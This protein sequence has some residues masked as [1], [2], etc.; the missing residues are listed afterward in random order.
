MSPAIRIRNWENRVSEELEDPIKFNKVMQDLQDIALVDAIRSL[1]LGQE[2]YL[3]IKH[4]SIPLKMNLY[5]S[6]RSLARDWSANFKSQLQEQWKRQ[7]GSVIYFPSLH[8]AHLECTKGV[9]TNKLRDHWAWQ[10]CGVLPHE[11]GH[12]NSNSVLG[13]WCQHS[14]QRNHFQISIWRYLL[15]S[16]LLSVV[17]NR[18]EPRH[19]Q[20]HLSGLEHAFGHKFTNLLNTVEQYTESF[21]DQVLQ[22]DSP[23][24][25]LPK[26]SSANIC[27][28]QFDKPASAS[29]IGQ[30]QYFKLPIDSVTWRYLAQNSPSSLIK[31][32]VTVLVIKEPGII[33]LPANSLSTRLPF[34]LGM[35]SEAREKE[36][37]GSQ[38]LFENKT[39]PVLESPTNDNDHADQIKGSSS[40]AENYLDTINESVS[41]IKDQT[42]ASILTHYAGIFWLYNLFIR[43]PEE[44]DAL[45]SDSRFGHKSQPWIWLWMVYPLICSSNQPNPNDQNFRVLAPLYAG[46][47]ESERLEELFQQIPTKAEFDLLCEFAATIRHRFLELTFPNVQNK[48]NTFIEILRRRARITRRGPW[49]EVQYSLEEVD[50]DVRRAGLDADPGFVVWLGTVVRFHYA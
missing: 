45:L 34:L 28:D 29:I 19:W 17:V 31:L 4:L 49:M 30:S 7:D 39:N 6:V 9:L 14:I 13:L 11:V 42:D 50:I 44:L 3:C 18:F 36:E 46:L 20:Q 27:L 32:L 10:Q 37:V 43:E 22:T 1:G 16:P 38:S 26:T 23:K 33:K 35:S 25:G 40:K 47:D 15:D 41:H 24:T 21:I 12:R 2:E 5:R 8:H 48:P